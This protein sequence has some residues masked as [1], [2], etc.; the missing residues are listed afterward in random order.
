MTLVLREVSDGD[1]E[2]TLHFVA[3]NGNQKFNHFDGGAHRWT[4]I[5]SSNEGWG[6]MVDQMAERQ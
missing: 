1:R 2:S 6:I 4:E 3:T 5:S